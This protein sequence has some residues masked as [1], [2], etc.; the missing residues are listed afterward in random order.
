MKRFPITALLL[1]LSVFASLSADAAQQC[2]KNDNPCNPDKLCSFKAAL[3]EKVLLYQLYLKNSQAARRS[4]SRE[5][6]R[7]DSTLRDE[8]IS[9]AQAAFPNETAQQQRVRAGQ[10]FQ[11]KVRKYASDN[12]RL[13]ACSNGAVNLELFPKKGYA[14]METNEAC[15]VWVNFEGGEYDPAGFGSGDQT[16]CQEFYDR[17]RAHEVIHQR[18]CEIAKKRGQAHTFDIDESIEEEIIAYRHTVRLTQAYVRLLSLQCSAR[19][20]PDELR[21]RADKIEK[22]IGPYLNR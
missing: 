22:L 2:I 18:R 1:G 19:A 10:I 13:P 21:K 5:G 4:G 3:A 12:F 6:V 15:Q 20:T 17:D 11:E 16:T 7:H 14:G 8:A 9:E